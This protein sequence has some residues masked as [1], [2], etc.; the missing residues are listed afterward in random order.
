MTEI[1]YLGGPC[2]VLLGVSDCKNKRRFMEVSRQKEIVVRKVLN[3]LRREDKM[4]KGPRCGGG[5][6]WRY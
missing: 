2:R 4:K 5:D 6:G 1:L 3:L